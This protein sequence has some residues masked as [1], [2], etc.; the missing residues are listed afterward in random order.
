MRGTRNAGVAL[1]NF[2][3]D[4]GFSLVELLIAMF[5]ASSVLFLIAVMVTGIYSVQHSVMDSSHSSSE[6]QN[7]GELFKA[8]VRSSTA[9]K[10]TSVTVAGQK[11]QLLQARVLT[12]TDPQN[13]NPAA[14]CQQYLWVVNKIYSSSGSSAA[15][16]PTV[17]NL[18]KWSMILPDVVPVVGGTGIFSQSG[19]LTSV[20][21]VTNPDHGLGAVVSTSQS[22]P[23]VPQVSAPCF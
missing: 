16:V 4:E 3:S 23:D 13:L 9:T 6:S 18:S 11:G 19:L 10:L 1:T 7:F 21:L 15:T 12:S 20:D 17:N 14:R 2:S 5:L 8:T 22:A